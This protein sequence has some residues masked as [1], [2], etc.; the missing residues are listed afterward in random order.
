MDIPVLVFDTCF[1]VFGW[2]GCGSFD[3]SHYLNSRIF[4]SV[5]TLLDF[6]RLQIKWVFYLLSW[7]RF[8][9]VFFL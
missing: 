4:F 9:I 3:R 8:G 5:E 7:A 2:F 1:L 6:E